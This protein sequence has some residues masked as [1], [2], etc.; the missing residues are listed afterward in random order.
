MSVDKASPKTI[1]SN[2]TL[3]RIVDSLCELNEA[4]VTEL[5]DRLDL[6]KSTVYKHL[7]SLE[8]HE[9]VVQNASGTYRL[10]FRFLTYGGAIRDRQELCQVVAPKVKQLTTQTTETC[11]FSIEEHGLGVYAYLEWG[12]HHIPRTQPVGQRFHLHM[13][14]SGKAI[15]A[16]LSDER[17]RTIIDERGLPEQTPNTITDEDFL[18]EEIH[19]IREQGYAV[20]AE[21]RFEGIRSI[22]AGIEHPQ[23]GQFG[24]ISMAAPATR[25]ENEELEEKYA[26]L[27]RSTVNEIDLKIQFN[28]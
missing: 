10:G 2:D 21:E 28:K 13:N 3:F 12:E 14:A 8:K 15:L 16:M 23:S 22:A 11:S 26:T 24:A 1:K 4:G 25:L 5:A 20:N 17:I 6:S 9:F 27:L 7:K 18:F 19:K